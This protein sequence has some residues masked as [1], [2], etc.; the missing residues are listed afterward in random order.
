MEG[1]RLGAWDP[2]SKRRKVG[3]LE[4]NPVK[5]RA[6]CMSRICVIRP[7]E[8]TLFVAYTW[9]TSCAIASNVTFTWHTSGKC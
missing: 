5:Q 4:N 2:Q 6:F 8:M 1:D 9:H 3:V 7:G